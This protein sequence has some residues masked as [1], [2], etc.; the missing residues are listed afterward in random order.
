MSKSLKNKI[1]GNCFPYRKSEHVV[2]KEN[3]NH[4]VKNQREVTERKEVLVC[5]SVK[6]KLSAP[7]VGAS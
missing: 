2:A 4:S 5:R 7:S 3:K 6:R 1:A